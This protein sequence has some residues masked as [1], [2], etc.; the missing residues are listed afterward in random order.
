MPRPSPA[1][2]LLVLIG[3]VPY[4][5]GR[6]PPAEGVAHLQKSFADYSGA[7]LVFAAKDLPE[8]P[9]HDIMPPLTE[10]GQLRAARIVLR[11]VRKLL[12]RYLGKM[13]LKAVG[14]FAACVSHQ[15]D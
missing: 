14:V 10:Q 5:Q 6:D 3:S 4:L 13:G 12:P 1:I 9:Y 7:R 11:E 2:A 15:G 8:G